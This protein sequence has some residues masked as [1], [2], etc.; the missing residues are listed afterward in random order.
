MTSN[1]TN[2]IEIF[3]S[4]QGEGPYIGYRQLFIRF[5]LCN[6]S[7][8]YCDTKFNPQDY[9]KIEECPGSESFKEIKNPVT[10]EQLIHEINRLT[11][12]H[13]H[14]LSLTGGEPLL[15]WEFLNQFLSEYQ[16]TGL[17]D[18]LKIYL[19]TNGTLPE[20]LEKVVDKIDIVSMDFK[21]ESS[22]GKPA[23]WDKHREF[24]RI[25]QKNNKEVFV[26]IVLTSKV[27]PDEVEQT[28][29]LILELDKKIP[30]ILQPVDSKDKEL[31]PEPVKLLEVQE[32]L[33]R[34]LPDVRIIPQIHKY[35]SLL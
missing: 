8:A 12:F 20:E 13:H 23:P 11:Y 6:L 15:N 27:S 4:I 33:L 16:E 25:I 24:I 5:A 21:L 7:C 28:A 19:E 26:K 2:V 29:D 9:C 31:I 35:L 17:D 1:E 10:V 22:N 30:V 34:K 3:S 32:A 18:T 14:S